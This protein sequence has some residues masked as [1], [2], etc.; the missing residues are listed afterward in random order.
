MTGRRSLCGGE[1]GQ[2]VA[3]DFCT[4]PDLALKKGAAYIFRKRWAWRSL[5]EI[6]QKQKNPKHF[7]DLNRAM[8]TG[9]QK[10]C[11]NEMQN[12]A[13]NHNKEIPKKKSSQFS[14]FL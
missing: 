12:F 11:A 6:I 4:H 13:L 9:G 14:M 2:K 5:K 8:R 1:G 10:L 7:D 3:I